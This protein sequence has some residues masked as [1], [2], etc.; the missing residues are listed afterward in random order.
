MTPRRG[1]GVMSNGLVDSLL[2]HFLRLRHFFEKVRFK[3]GKVVID[4]KDQT[5]KKVILSIR[6]TYQASTKRAKKI[7][8]DHLVA[9]TKRSRK[10]LIKLLAKPA[11]QLQKKKGSG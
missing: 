6:P 2:G 11:D 3:I 1:V 5:V 4:V 9:I 7:T 8:L 10:H